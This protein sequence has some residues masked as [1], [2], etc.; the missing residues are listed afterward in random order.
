MTDP[1]FDGT[2][3]LT[4]GAVAAL[5]GVT[6]RALHHWDSIGLVSPSERTGSGYRLYTAA[7]LARTHRVLIYRELGVALNDIAALL[8]APS[9]TALDSLIQQRD[10]VRERV[11]ELQRMS[12]ALDRMI[13]ARQSGLLLS[14]DEQIRIFGKDW[15][16]ARVDEARRRWGDTPEWTQYA[17]RAASRSAAEWQEVAD[18]VRDLEAALAEACRAGVVPGS[19]YADLLAEQHRASIGRYF[20]CS[21][22]MHVCIGRRYVTEPGYADYYD[23]RQPGLT[24]W[25]RDIIDANARAHGV[26]PETAT[27]Q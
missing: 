17:E 6:I 13:E 19:E 7:D 26:D 10:Q 21:H 22:A 14:A 27:W 4:V 12:E 3:G 20:D 9:S 15:Q 5:V 23:G 24:A 25:L 8:D 16:P 2:D 1:A 11:T 18:D